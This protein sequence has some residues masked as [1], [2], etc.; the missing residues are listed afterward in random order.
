MQLSKRRIRPPWRF[1]PAGAFYGF[2]YYLSSRSDFPIESPFSGFDKL[3][4]IAIFSVLGTLL[5]WGFDAAAHGRRFHRPA[6]A[7]FLGLLGGVLDEVHQLFVP[8]RHADVWD[9]AADMIGT[10]AG[11]FL[12]AVLCRRVRRMPKSESRP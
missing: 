4:H 7:F 5:Y 2:I 1:F 6:L 10:A 9:A 12:G 3:A 11:V 8:G